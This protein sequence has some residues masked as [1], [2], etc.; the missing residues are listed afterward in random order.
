[1]SVTVG[2][3]PV[4]A[5]PNQDGT[6]LGFTAPNPLP[7]P[8]AGT[9]DLKVTVPGRDMVTITV[10]VAQPHIQTAWRTGPR[11]ISVAAD[12]WRDPNNPNAATPQVLANGLPCGIVSQSDHVLAA[13]LPDDV[14]S[15]GLQLVVIDDL[16]R[17]SNT[18]VLSLPQCHS[19]WV[20]RGR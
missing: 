2:T 3:I 20:R 16:G 19:L 12:G 9:V 5:T 11:T 18:Y 14:N 17:P 7:D 4:E 10:P 8:G 1:V 15:A 13:T 6:T